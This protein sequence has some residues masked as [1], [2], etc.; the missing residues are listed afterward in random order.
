MLAAVRVRARVRVILHNVVLV[1]G[2]FECAELL[3]V[4]LPVG[5]RL[6]PTHV[7]LVGHIVEVLV[8]RRGERR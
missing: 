6:L 8:V 4:R 3:L 1:P 5:I 7:R 2:P